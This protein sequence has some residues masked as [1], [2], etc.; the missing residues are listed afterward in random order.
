MIEYRVV[1]HFSSL[2]DITKISQLIKS[3][4]RPGSVS[5]R[6]P[7]DSLKKQSSIECARLSRHLKCRLYVEAS[8]ERTRER[9]A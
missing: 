5:D 4:L 6:V 8:F 9:L 1:P 7:S 3:D 2:A